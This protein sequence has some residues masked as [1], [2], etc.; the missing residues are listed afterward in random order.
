MSATSDKIHI[1]LMI[2]NEM[3]PITIRPETEE[4]F[5]AASRTPT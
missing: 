2:G 3:H 5:R 1:Q 4:T